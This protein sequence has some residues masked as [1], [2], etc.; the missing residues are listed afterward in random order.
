MDSFDSIV[1]M[2]DVRDAQTRIADELRERIMSGAVALG[3]TIPPYS[4]LAATYEVSMA[5][6]Q[7]AVAILRQEGLVTTAPGRGTFVI[8][9][10]P[11]TE[12]PWARTLRHLEARIDDMAAEI[13]KLQQIVAAAA[14]APGVADPGPARTKRE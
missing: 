4:E 10:E 5:T 12:E 2:V 1:F 6:A 9:Q 3:G 7:R 11:I 14:A 13:M 8:A